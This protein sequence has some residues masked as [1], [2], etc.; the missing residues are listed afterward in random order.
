MGARGK[1][2]IYTTHFPVVERL[3]EGQVASHSIQPYMRVHLS[4]LECMPSDRACHCL[5][6]T[7]SK[8]DL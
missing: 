3:Y 4:W 5:S 6:I 1:V 2:I 7:L 8:A